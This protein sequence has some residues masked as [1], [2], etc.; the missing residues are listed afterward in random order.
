MCS[1][2]WKQITKDVSVCL[3]CGATLAYGAAA[4]TPKTPGD[5]LRRA[6]GSHDCRDVIFLHVISADC[7]RIQSLPQFKLRCF[8][9]PGEERA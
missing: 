4:Q 3:L 1:H 7:P 8:L 5:D 9:T 6:R 2:D